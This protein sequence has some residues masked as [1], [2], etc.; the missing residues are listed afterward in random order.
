[1]N[2]F[3]II[4]IY[5]LSTLSSPVITKIRIPP[6]QCFICH[7][8]QCNRSVSFIL[9]L[10][11]ELIYVTRLMIG[12]LFI[13]VVNY[14][15]LYLAICTGS[16][17]YLWYCYRFI[18]DLMSAVT[19]LYLY[20]VFVWSGGAKNNPNLS[21]QILHKFYHM[22]TCMHYDLMQGERYFAQYHA[23]NKFYLWIH[24]FCYLLI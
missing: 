16:R 12:V 9:F 3:N 11:S 1:M 17:M 4:V 24:C 8:F 15:I 10:Q 13:C 19:S 6:L 18:T 5:S 14:F 23:L 22:Y 20:A 2:Q 7:L 21:F